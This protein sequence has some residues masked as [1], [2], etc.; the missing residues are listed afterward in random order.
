[1]LVGAKGESELGG[2]GDAKMEI[3]ANRMRKGRRD[4]VFARE[5]FACFGVSIFAYSYALAGAIQSGGRK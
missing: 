1:M 3:T 2:G 4:R 5:R